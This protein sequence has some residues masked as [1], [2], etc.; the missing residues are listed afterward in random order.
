MGSKARSENEGLDSL[1]N[2]L[3]SEIIAGNVKDGEFYLITCAYS[4]VESFTYHTN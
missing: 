1:A 4:Y 2:D 3:V